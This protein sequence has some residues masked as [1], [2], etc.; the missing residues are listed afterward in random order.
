MCFGAGGGGQVLVSR[1]LLELLHQAPA[2]A[3]SQRTSEPEPMPVLG[4]RAASDMPDL[5]LPHALT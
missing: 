5:H 1:C 4:K 3:L 2:S